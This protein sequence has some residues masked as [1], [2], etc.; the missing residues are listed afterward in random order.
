MLYANGVGLTI[1]VFY[2]LV[3]PVWIGFHDGTFDTY[4]RNAALSPA[5]ERLA[6]DGNNGPISGVF[7]EAEGTAFD[8][9]V[10]SAPICPGQSSEVFVTV[11]IPVGTSFYFSYAS[12]VLPSNDAFVANGNPMAHQVINDAGEFIELN[13]D[14]M[15]SAVLDAGTEVND[16]VPENTAF[17]GQSKF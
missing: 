16:E 17:F 14:I 1:S 5:M 9:T 6:E 15:G 4:D 12:M 3:T 8:L 13:I 11:S 2:C 7:A 10:G